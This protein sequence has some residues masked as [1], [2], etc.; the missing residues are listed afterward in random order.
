MKIFSIKRQK[1]NVILV[2]YQTFPDIMPLVLPYVSKV[3]F[4]ECSKFTTSKKNLTAAFKPL[5]TIF[6]YTIKKVYSM[7]I[8]SNHYYPTRGNFVGASRENITNAE[9][10][11]T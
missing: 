1:I 5:F 11:L 2:L 9:N 8:K 6:K 3:K 7:T 10:K 4:I